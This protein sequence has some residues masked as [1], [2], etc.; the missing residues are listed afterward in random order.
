M[1]QERINDFVTLF[2]VIDPIGTLPIFLAATA[3][4]K[5]DVRRKTAIFAVLFAF[6]VLLFF[7]AFGQHLLAH[8]GIS[9]RAF[10]IAGGIV[11]FVFALHMVL[12]AD[13][14]PTANKGKVDAVEVAIHPV[15]IPAIAGPGAML[16]VVLLTDSS[17]YDV[18][19]QIMTSMVLAVVLAVQLFILLLAS[20][21]A[22]LIGKG[23]ANIIRRVM[24]MILAA[25]AANMSLTAI[26]DWLKLPPL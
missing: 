17:R 13:E 8:I 16:A 1:L 3:S 26:G 5:A 23:G 19:D 18:T 6:G 21:V 7:I 9:L 15:A 10:Q 25:V 20:P 11:L 22:R 2:V 24:G 12:G 4:L 14:S